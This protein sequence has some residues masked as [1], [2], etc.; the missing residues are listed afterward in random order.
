MIHVTYSTS[1][2]QRFIKRILTVIVIIGLISMPGCA[3]D[4]KNSEK[5]FDPVYNK[6]SWGMT[7][8]EII[9][10]LNLKDDDYEIITSD[11]SYSINI[12]LNKMVTKFGQN[13]TVYLELS[14]GI[15]YS[16]YPKGVLFC[17]HLVYEQVDY[18]TLKKVMKSELGDEYIEW[19]QT[20]FIH[21]TT[22]E[23]KDTYESLSKE[24]QKK[25]EEYKESFTNENIEAIRNMDKDAKQTHAI[26][27]ITL[28]Q[29]T[30][31][32]SGSLAV[33]YFGGFAVLLNSDK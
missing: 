4:K 15:S 28:T 3:G 5:G 10:A 7:K 26:N 8:E 23:S 29:S 31:D 32:S 1:C 16:M 14:N 24:E 6:L 21:N 9:T 33:H 27:R 11:D 22:W 20:N 30:L 2:R 18:D 13:A 25:V 19:S 17:V 12:K